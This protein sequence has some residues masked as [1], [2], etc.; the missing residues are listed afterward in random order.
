M[1]VPLTIVVELRY[2]LSSL[3]FFTK[4]YKLRS[5]QET[6]VHDESRF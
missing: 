5:K 3:Q 2:V 6:E 1:K 4:D